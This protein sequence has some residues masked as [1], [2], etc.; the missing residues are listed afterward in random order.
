MSHCELSDPL[1]V[2]V[3]RS[4]LLCIAMIP[5]ADLT[6]HGEDTPAEEPDDG[7]RWTVNV[8][9]YETARPTDRSRVQNMLR[10][11][12]KQDWDAPSAPSVEEH[13]ESAWKLCSTDPRLPYA[14]G[15][16]H[17]RHQ[18]PAEAIQRFEQAQNL[19]NSLFPPA[20]QAAAWC[21]IEQG[22]LEPGV[23]SLRQLAEGLMAIDPRLLDDDYCLELYQWLGQ[24]H[25][26]VK[27]IDGDGALADELAIIDATAT[28]SHDSAVRKAFEAG[29]MELHRKFEQM[30]RL[31]LR[32]N[33]EIRAQLRNEQ[34]AVEQ[35]LAAVETSLE[36]DRAELVRQRTAVRAAMVSK[37]LKNHEVDQLK[38]ANRDAAA[39]LPNLIAELK[40]KESIARTRRDTT[41]R[42]I[43]QTVEDGYEYVTETYFDS[44]NREKT[45]TVRRKRYK[46]ILVTVPKTT[47]ET[48]S[49]RANWQIVNDALVKTEDQ[50][51]RLQ[52][53]LADA[54]AAAEQVRSLA[55][56]VSKSSRAGYRGLHQRIA[57][58]DAE[59]RRL[60]QRNRELTGWIEQPATFRDHVRTIPPY[61]AWHVEVERDDVLQ[62]LLTPSAKK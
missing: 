5:G 28:V 44:Q 36:T 35:E 16:V 38:A 37:N 19:E 3:L 54:S 56:E 14:C 8:A 49:D 45:R 29:R 13:F 25:E 11:I 61:V 60:T 57:A 33:E 12:L 10:K 43:E 1:P 17:W 24:M 22:E 26:F 23:R 42:V 50:L 62:S 40:V 55:L 58:G 47:A 7:P 52:A 32:S 34:A 2:R 59:Q 21:R 51:K 48:E 46:T 31:S 18:R 4:A 53:L 20:L 6:A 9:W 39:N 15:L 27:L 30:A 41:T